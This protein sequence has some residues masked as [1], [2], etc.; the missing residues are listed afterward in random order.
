MTTTTDSCSLDLSIA[1][2]TCASCVLRVEKALAAVPG[3]SSATVNLATERAH[4]EFNTD[5]NNSSPLSEQAIAAVKKAGYEAIKIETNVAPT[6]TLTESR[7]QEAQHLKHALIL[8][9]IL[10]L[11]VFI[12]EMGSHLFA[13]MHEF[14]HIHI[15]MQRSWILQSILTTLVLIGPGR[16]FFTKGLSALAKLSPEMNSLVAMGAGSAWMYSML[17]T[18]WPQALPEGTR[19]VYFEAAAVI[20]TLILLGRMLEAM[21]KG[22]TGMAIKHL[23]GLQ[24]RQAR[25]LRD[26]NPIDVPIESVIPGDLVLVRPGE[27]IPVDGVITEGSSYIDESMIT[28]EPIPVTKNL[29]DQV[30]GGTINTTSSFTFKATHTGADTVLARIIRMVENAQGTKLPIQAMVDKVT[31][32][33]V[34]AIM[35]CSFFTFVVWLLFGPSPSLSFA[36]VN[37]VAV[38]IIACP[39]AMGLATPTSIMVG[40]GRAAQLGVLFRQGDALQRLRDVEVIAFDKTGTLTMGKP[41]M[42]DLLVTESTQD[43]DSLLAVAAAMQMHSEHPIAHA[44]VN[45]AQSNKLLLPAARDFSAIN[46]AGVRAVVQGKLVL[47]GSENLMKENGIDVSHTAQQIIQWGQEGKTP[48][49]LAIEGKLVALIAVADPIKPSAKTAL[50]ALKKMNVQTLMITGDNIYTAQAVAKELGIDQLHAHTLPEGKVAL[51][52]QQKKDG[53]VIAFVGDGI[54]DAP[55][56]ATAD[57]GIAIGTG[58]DVAIESASVVLMSDDLQGVVNAIGLSHA[59]MTNIKQNLFW[60]FAYNVALV[61]LAAGILYP[62]SGTLLS[63][64]FAAGA[65]ACSSVFVIVNALRLKRFKPQA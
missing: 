31:A 36:L 16:D 3:V 32:W 56:L 28:G 51:L 34:P 60:A 5:S 14:V 64:M 49:Y 59:T 57:V 1:G 45:A 22:Q 44:I 52:Q 11:P 55:A 46:G 63:P 38:M 20:V 12:L 18:Y 61:P 2:M 62:V 29:R 42:T 10:T 26:S 58:T 41:V 23:I 48:I 40:T 53:R 13:A 24:P 50:A 4:L 17:A 39:C 37:A 27:R 7:Q 9:T 21:A 54:N 30:T 47:S 33:F 35:A 6:D 25:I 65:M 15:G 8:S 43:R 19:F